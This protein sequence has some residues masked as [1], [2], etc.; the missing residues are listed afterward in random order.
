MCSRNER[1]ISNC[2]K[3]LIKYSPFFLFIML[4]AQMLLKLLLLMMFCCCCCSHIGKFEDSTEF[5]KGLG[6]SL[7]EGFWIELFFLMMCQMSVVAVVVVDDVPNTC[8]SSFTEAFQWIAFS[9]RQ[10]SIDIILWSLKFEKKVFKL[11]KH[12]S[13]CLPLTGFSIIYFRSTK[14]SVFLI[15][16]I[17]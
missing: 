12:F 9:T 5:R 16:R 15:S 14:K 10:T 8:V 2:N 3:S 4:H 7:G 13:S 17:S 11:E 1:K 6:C